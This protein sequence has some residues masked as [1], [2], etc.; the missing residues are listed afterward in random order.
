M[1]ARLSA[2]RQVAIV[3]AA[4]SPFQRRTGRARWVRLTLQTCLAAI[5]DAGLEPSQ[6]D[7]FTTGRHLSVQCRAEPRRRGATS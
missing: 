4:Q 5:T 3:G 2:S 7:G 1:V 6:I